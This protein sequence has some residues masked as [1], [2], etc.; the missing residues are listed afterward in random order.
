MQA[1]SNP[2]L[3]TGDRSFQFGDGVFTT[4]LVRHGEPELWPLHLARLQQGVAR[5]GIREPDW[6]ELSAQVRAAIQA[7]QQVIK[8]LISRGQAGRGYS[9][10]DVTGPAVYLTTA[11]LP[12]FSHWQSAGI[13][14]G[15]ARLQ[16]GCQPLLAGIKHN[17]RLE[18]VLLKQELASTDWDDLLVLD[19]RGFVTEAIA[20]NLLFFRAG[21]WFTPRLDQAGVAGV[22]RA[23]LMMCCS[24]EEVNW[25]LDELQGVEAI[26][27]C[28]ALT[29]VVP[30]RQFLDREL[31]MPPVHQLQQELQCYAD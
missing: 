11:A 19:Q 14:L 20:A 3:T 9:P 7:P 1:V 6:A 27:L 18:Q 8:V 13:R 5:L 23:R 29:A 10:A 31:A 16:L 22:M 21:R 12:D 4:I 2:V 28:N 30:V 26:C 25:T 24:V 15:L 17:N